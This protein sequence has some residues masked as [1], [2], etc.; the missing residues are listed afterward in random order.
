[1][2]ED[3]LLRYHGD[4]ATADMVGIAG[5]VVDFAVNVRAGGPPEWLAS[6]LREEIVFLG[7]YPSPALIDAARSAA[8]RR[9]GVDPEC[10]LLLAGAAEGFSLIAGLGAKHPVV[11][12]PGFTEPEV[13]LRAA[14]T[15]VER[16]VLESPFTLGDRIPPAA[17]DLVV[18]GNPTNP[19]GV[20]HSAD[21]LRSWCRPGRI[22]VVDEA[23]MD[24]TDEST[25]VARDVNDHTG[26]VVMRSLTKTFSLAG[27]RCGYL[28]AAPDLVRRLSVSRP[29]WP[30]GTLQAIAIRNALRDGAGFVS[31][32]RVTVEDQRARMRRMLSNAGFLVHTDSQA[33]YLLVTPPVDDPEATRLAL[34]GRG[35]LVRRCDT[36]PGLDHTYWRLAVRGAREVATLVESVTGHAPKNIKERGR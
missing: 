29:H 8:A 15:T 11:V 16:M 24:L 9:H 17:A 36:F 23:F 13:A 6:A 25:S 22:T 28:L 32:Q 2:N 26:L 30:V 10:V 14:G 20:L 21:V 27:L 1:M 35:I 31:E 3:D 5:D 34:A 7:S 4:L 33:P 19:T 18:V 12:H